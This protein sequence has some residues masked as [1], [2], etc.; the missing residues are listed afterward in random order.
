M[1]Y[2]VL[3][4]NH[5]KSKLSKDVHVLLIAKNKMSSIL[6]YMSDIDKKVFKRDVASLNDIYE[7]VIC[8][9]SKNNIAESNSFS[10]NLAIE[11]IFT[12]MVNHF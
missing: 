10:V 6:K 1:T 5:A 4:F 8:Y 9:F 3:I 2:N 7:F 12:N 11:E